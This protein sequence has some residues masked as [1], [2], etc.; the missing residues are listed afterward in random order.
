ML[1]LLRF[2][3]TPPQSM[4]IGQ[5][6]F[7]VGRFDDGEYAVL[8]YRAYLRVIPATSGPEVLALLGPARAFRLRVGQRVPERGGRT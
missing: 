5:G 7:S 6:H 1:N 2:N 3:S 8:M 4:G